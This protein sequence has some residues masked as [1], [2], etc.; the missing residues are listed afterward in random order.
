MSHNIKELEG[1]FLQL[2]INYFAVGID[3][4]E[5]CQN[6]SENKGLVDKCQDLSSLFDDRIGTLRAWLFEWNGVDYNPE[7]PLE[8]QGKILELSNL[9]GDNF[10]K[11]FLIRIN[12]LVNQMLILIENRCLSDFHD[13]FYDLCLEI[14]E[15]LGSAID[16]IKFK[17]KK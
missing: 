6:N 15:E 5:L 4:F 16:W 8:Q 14:E 12:E 10:D 1:D 7:I 9:T 13:E 11:H 3:M 2:L 17:M